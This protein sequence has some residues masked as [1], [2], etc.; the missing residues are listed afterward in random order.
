[1]FGSR[2]NFG[3]IS[4]H[5]I[6]DT[7]APMLTRGSVTLSQNPS[8]TL[9]FSEPVRQI[10]QSSLRFLGQFLPIIVSV[11]FQNRNSSLYLPILPL[12]AESL[13]M[14]Y[15]DPAASRLLLDAASSQIVD[16][17]G[18]KAGLGPALSVSGE[19]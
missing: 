16:A 14:L 15:C 11:N 5:V 18:N 8:I 2:K 7:T 6:N 17:T 19:I 9:E 12:A 1:M 4:I 3:P 10:S 13:A